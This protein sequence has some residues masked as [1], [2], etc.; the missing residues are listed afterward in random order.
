MEDLLRQAAVRPPPSP[1]IRRGRWYALFA[2]FSP[3][4]VLASLTGFNAVTQDAMVQ[5]PGGYLLLAA[6]LAP[7]LTFRVAKRARRG[8]TGLYRTLQV[9]IGLSVAG[10]AIA[11]PVL[12]SRSYAH[13]TGGKPE[14]ALA[15]LERCGHD[16]VNE[17]YVRADG[18]EVVGQGRRAPLDYAPGCA[19]VQLLTG[20]H[21][22]AWLRVRAHSRRAGRGQLSWPVRA[23]D[24]F[25][26]I[27]L[28]GLPR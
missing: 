3:L 27:P 20:D 12:A 9:T 19:E 14:R 26:D 10:L 16:C 5:G 11:Y 7:F 15:V 2:L 22:F 17:V 8:H 6:L 23:S 25:S 21:G 4:L 24:C 28:S 13:A 1:V 18:S